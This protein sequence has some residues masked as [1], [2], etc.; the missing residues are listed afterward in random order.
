MRDLWSTRQRVLDRIL[1]MLLITPLFLVC[2]S[3][4]ADGAEAA[5]GDDRPRLM[6]LGDSLVAG[7]GL[8]QGQAF[9]DAREGCACMTRHT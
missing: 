1:I 5:D 8:P 9:Q 4:L 3:A 7:H 6:V 2:L